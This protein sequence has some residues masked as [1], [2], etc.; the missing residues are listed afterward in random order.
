M[1]EFIAPSA[2]F[3]VMEKKKEKKSSTAKKA[4]L[5]SQVLGIADK[6]FHRSGCVFVHLSSAVQAL[7]LF[8]LPPP[9][10]LSLSFTLISVSLDYCTSASLSS[11]PVG[12]VWGEPM[13]LLY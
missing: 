10:L 1:R 2:A 12:A 13:G 6:S 9:P 11:A 5:V 7:F 4:G 3:V 8:F